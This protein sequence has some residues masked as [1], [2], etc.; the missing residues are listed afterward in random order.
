ML[1]AI[2]VSPC[3]TLCIKIMGEILITMITSLDLIRV[4]GDTHPSQKQSITITKYRRSG[5]FRR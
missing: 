1:Q 4:N 5:Y 2:Y 3:T